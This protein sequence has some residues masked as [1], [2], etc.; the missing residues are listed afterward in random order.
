MILREYDESDLD[1]VTE[2]YNL[3]RESAGCFTAGFISAQQFK[4]ISKHEQILVASSNGLLIGF[5]SVWPP[6]KFIHHLY[7]RPDHQSNGVAIRLIEACKTRYGLP[8]SLKSLV[9]NKNACR[10]YE[11]NNW[12]VDGTGSGSEGAYNHYWLRSS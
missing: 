11:R 3:A 8:L 9:R 7:V 4:S 5:I 6:E 1:E 12:V 2:V 10:F